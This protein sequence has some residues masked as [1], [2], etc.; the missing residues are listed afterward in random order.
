MKPALISY[1]RHHTQ[2]FSDDNIS[3]REYLETI[4]DI[5]VERLVRSWNHGR[6]ANAITGS[7]IGPSWLP[8]W[9]RPRCSI[10]RAPLRP[11]PLT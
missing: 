5:C 4:L 10:A 3:E 8:S 11:W 2:R 1:I 6:D 7:S 9:W